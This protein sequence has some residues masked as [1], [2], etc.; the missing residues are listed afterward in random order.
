MLKHNLRE[1][2]GIYEG[3]MLKHNLPLRPSF[4]HW[5]AGGPGARPRRQGSC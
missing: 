4:H 3:V 1:P 5:S 2:T